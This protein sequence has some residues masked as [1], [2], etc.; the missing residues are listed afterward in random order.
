[1][2]TEITLSEFAIRARLKIGDLAESIGKRIQFGEECKDL[3]ED[4]TFL[5]HFLNAL[6]SQFNDWTDNEKMVRMEHV[7]D[8]FDLIVNPSYTSD[9]L[10]KFT[11]VATLKSNATSDFTVPPGMGYLYVVDGE[12]SVVPDVKYTLNDL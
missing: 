9:W 3:V 5:R 10:Q 12:L 7:A 8:R 4:S 2:Y 6:N 1:M 11:P